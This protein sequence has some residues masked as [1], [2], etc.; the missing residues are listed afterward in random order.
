MIRQNG[1]TID[2]SRSCCAQFAAVAQTIQLSRRT[3]PCGP[4]WC[5]TNI[6]K[7]TVRANVAPATLEP[8]NER[9]TG[10]A[11]A[12]KV[13][14]RQ[15]YSSEQQA[16]ATGAA[17]TI[18]CCVL[19]AKGIAGVSTPGTCAQH[20]GVWCCFR[21]LRAFGTACGG[22]AAAAAFLATPLRP[23]VIFLQSHCPKT[24]P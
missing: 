11:T 15:N 20:A 22:A 7:R 17:N 8:S 14:L 24:Y 21:A 3:R 12:A 23:P 10:C 19:R 4:W 13:M 5:A 1:N 2:G 6:G 16:L 9:E 18:T